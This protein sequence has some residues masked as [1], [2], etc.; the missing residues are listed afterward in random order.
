[1]REVSPLQ[2]YITLELKYKSHLVLTGLKR[3]TIDSMQHCSINI[4]RGS[5]VHTNKGIKYHSVT[6]FELVLGGI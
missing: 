2:T 4:V 3:N 1:M 5:K 6:R